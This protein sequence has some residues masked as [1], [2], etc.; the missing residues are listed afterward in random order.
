MS[1][2]DVSNKLPGKIALVTGGNSGI[3]LPTAERFV[4]EGAYVFI[5]GRPHLIASR[6][7]NVRGI[8]IRRGDIVA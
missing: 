7:Y 3:G 4:A 6:T 5:T 8:R 2:P 1:L